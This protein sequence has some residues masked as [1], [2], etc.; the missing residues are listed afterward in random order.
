MTIT[1]ANCDLDRYPSYYYDHT[2]SCFFLRKK[3]FGQNYQNISNIYP[4]RFT[5]CL[6]LHGHIKTAE[7]QTIIQQYGDWYTG[8]WWVGCYIWYSEERQGRAVAPP[9]PLIAVPNVTA[10]PSMASVPTSYYLMWH[11]N[12]L[13]ILLVDYAHV[14]NVCYVKLCMQSRKTSQKRRLVGS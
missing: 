1:I 2:D 3:Q 9:S 6:T 7:Q 5:C 8:R 4:Q 12:C 13:W 10:H 11:Y 14:H